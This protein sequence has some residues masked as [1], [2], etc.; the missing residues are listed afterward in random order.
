MTNIAGNAEEDNQIIA[1]DDQINTHH[2][3][4]AHRVNFDIADVHPIK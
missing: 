4:V 2:C 3:A 1:N